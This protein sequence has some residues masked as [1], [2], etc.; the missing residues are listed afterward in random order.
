MA[1]RLVRCGLVLLTWHLGLRTF[2]AFGPSGPF[3]SD[4]RASSRISRRADASVKTGEV[5]TWVNITR[6][7]R[8]AEKASQVL[9]VMHKEA[10]NPKMSL[11]SVS[12]A[13]CRL[14]RLPRRTL[15]TK[16][17]RD[18]SM[19][20]FLSL[21]GS[22]LKE[23]AG[24]A[25]QTSSI[26]WA[27]GKLQ[28]RMRSELE[29]LWPDLAQAVAK[30]GEELDAQ[31]V[32]NVVYTVAVLPT[33]AFES[34]AGVLLRLAERIPAVLP[35]M[36]SQEA[37]NLMWAI[38]QL[39]R[40]SRQN[41]VPQGLREVVP[42]L[43]ARCGLL[44]P[45][46]LPQAL[47][48]ACW[49]LALVGHADPDFLAAAAKKV[50]DEADSWKPAGALLDLPSVLCAFA[51]LKATGHE[52]MLQAAAK[53][54]QPRLGQLNDWGISAMAWSYQQLD[55]ED[56]LFF[57]AT[58]DAELTSRGLGTNLARSRHGPEQWPKAKRQ[59]TDAAKTQIAT[60]KEEKT[61]A[62]EERAQTKQAIKDARSSMGDD[63]A[64]AKEVKEKCGAKAKEWE[65]RQK[66]RSSE[67][68]AVAKAI[69][70]LSDD[71]AHE[72]FGK[73]FSFLQ[74]SEVNAR[75]ERAAAALEKAGRRD[76]RLQTLALETKLDGF[77]I[78][79]EKIDAMV[80]ALKEEQSAEVKKKDYCLSELQKNKPTGKT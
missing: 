18:P 9:K 51:R 45:Q 79:K 56:E 15:T 37:A 27:A 76:Q 38:G 13:W 20:E 57:R 23:P 74:V 75:R 60:K 31:G 43:V 28:S 8:Q 77:T 32:A 33:A 40:S 48:N 2:A 59:E 67:T 30:V 5:V 71:D 62:D 63:I 12:A 58:L 78:V 61:A 64:F 21:S 73:T 7:I 41:A 49:G 70:V 39:S 14:A 50:E 68:E 52:G 44:L 26:F 17:L 34:V 29:P 53:K 11:V 47:A 66:T 22:L 19:N 16:A 65:K 54:L 1:S 80:G 3:G 25:R 35:E 69:E 55:P 24:Y 6:R 42:A 72:V 10:Q 4:S 36:N 46:A